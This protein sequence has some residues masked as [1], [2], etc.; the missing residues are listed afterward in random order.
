MKFVRLKSVTELSRENVIA[1][2][3][4]GLTVALLGAFVL[5]FPRF[6]IGQFLIQKS[7]DLPF[8]VRDYILKERIAVT[9]AVIAY[10]DELS[11][12]RLCQPYGAGWDRSVH[13]RFVEKIHAAGAAAVVFIARAASPHAPPTLTF[14][15]RLL[16]VSTVSARPSSRAHPLRL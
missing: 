1:G 3:I 16:A 7:Y 13:A 14:L 9:N 6:F 11:H 15:P 2:V 4:C 10:M 8:M 12:D 5:L